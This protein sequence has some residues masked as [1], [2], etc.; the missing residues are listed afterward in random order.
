MRRSSCR[1]SWSKLG[2]YKVVSINKPPKFFFENLDRWT[3][4]QGG[5][6]TCMRLKSVGYSWAD[7]EP[8]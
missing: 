5:R 7:E 8:P 1:Q 3:D 4:G 6:V 2:V